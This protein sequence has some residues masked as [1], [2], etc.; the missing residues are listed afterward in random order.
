MYKT[1]FHKGQ[2]FGRWQLEKFIKAGGNGEVWRAT[3]TDDSSRVVAIKLLKRID[4]KG[5]VRFRD[6]IKVLKENVDIKGLLESKDS[7]KQGIAQVLEAVQELKE[8]LARLI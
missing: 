4:N 7:Q 8:A 1:K 6:E 2:R 3:D 5:Y